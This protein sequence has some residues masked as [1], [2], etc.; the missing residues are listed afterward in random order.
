MSGYATEAWRAFD[1]WCNEHDPDG[2]L[3][4]LDRVLAYTRWASTNSIAPYLDPAQRTPRNAV[5]RGNR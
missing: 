2:E 4:P 3:E 1:R 5:H